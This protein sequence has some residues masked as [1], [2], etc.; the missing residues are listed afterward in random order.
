[1]KR[2]KFLLSSLALF[3]LTLT[4]GTF[5]PLQTA[6][7]TGIVGDVRV[8]FLT[9]AQF[10][11]RAGSGWILADGRDVTGSSYHSITGRTNAPDTRGRALRMKDHSAG[12]ND[13]GEIAI[14]SNQNEQYRSH[15]HQF[16]VGHN[17]GFGQFGAH[18][19]GGQTAAPNTSSAGGNETRMDNTSTNFF[20]RIN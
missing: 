12:V 13:D 9:E 11:A 4:A 14:G 6:P 18:A 10:Q 5:T 20:I 3:S 8:S 19:P 17:L 16:F 2:R 7:A 15:Y 1:M